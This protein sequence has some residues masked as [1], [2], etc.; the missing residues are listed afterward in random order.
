MMDRN[1]CPKTVLSTSIKASHTAANS[2]VMSVRSPRNGLRCRKPSRVRQSILNVLVWTPLVAV[3]LFGCGGLT[4]K[5][6]QIAIAVTPNKTTLT[7]GAIQPFVATVT[8]AA[9]TAVTWTVS[10]AG[11]GGAACGTIS[12]SG[13]YAAPATVP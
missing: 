1:R 3:I 9:N 2:V 12:N 11:C 8:G 6:P 4:V 7:S 5:S 13:L 10:G